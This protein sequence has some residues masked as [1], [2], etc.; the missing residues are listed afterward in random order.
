MELTLIDYQEIYEL[1]NPGPLDTKDCGTLC[2]AA[3]CQTYNQDMGMYL[4]PGE[5]KMFNSEDMDWLSWETH[6]PQ[7]YDFPGS[8]L[9]PVY[10]AKCLKPCPREK[11]PIQC[12]TFPLTPHITKDGNLILIWE[13]LKLPY[14]CPLIEKKSSLNSNYVE[15]LQKA[16]SKL[17]KNSLIKDLINWDSRQRE[18]EKLTLS[19]YL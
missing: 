12:R 13:T 9:Q 8:W 18:K 4:M 16:W 15:G 5:E 14:T 19:P 3:C 17:I 7:N 1:L 11:R 6:N 2:K 10:Y